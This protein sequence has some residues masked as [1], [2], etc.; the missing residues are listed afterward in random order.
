M[1]ATSKGPLEQFSVTTLETQEV[2]AYPDELVR[3]L[4]E[5]LT[6][7]QKFVPCEFLYDDLGSKYFDEFAESKEYYLPHKEKEILR[8][9]GAELCRL[10]GCCDIYELGS[11]SA[12]KTSILLRSYVDWGCD[13]V[14]HPIDINQSIME[15]GARNILNL[16]P[17]IK[18]NC[19]VGTFERALSSMGAPDRDR[20]VLFLGSSLSQLHEDSLLYELR[21]HLSPGEYLLVAYDLQKSAD[22]LVSAYQ[23]IEAERCSRN[24]LDHLNWRFDGNFDNDRYEFLV[25]YN[26]VYNR[27]ETHLKS[28]TKHTVRLEKLDL[29]LSIDAGE[30][31]CTGHQRK[32]RYDDVVQRLFRAGFKEVRT[33]MDADSWYAITLFAAG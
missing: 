22:I 18:I 24:L 23:N 28:T 12:K 6:L 26:D 7:P 32:F 11:G 4:I 14:F 25:V 27:C 10:T 8:T 2:E 9:Y 29:T 17:G 15:E 16:L 5:S 33:F 1:N 30:T 20:M 21:S 19:L 13:F 31:I 3:E